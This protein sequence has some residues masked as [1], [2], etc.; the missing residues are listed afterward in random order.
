MIHVQL[1]HQRRLCCRGSSLRGPSLPGAAGAPQFGWILQAFW[2]FIVP[3]LEIDSMRKAGP[4]VFALLALLIGAAAA[5]FALTALAQQEAP[6]TSSSRW[7]DGKEVQWRASSAP[8]CD[9]SNVELRML[10][11]SSASGSARLKSATFACRRGG[12]DKGLERIFGLVAPG[13][14]AVA[15]ALT[16][17]CAEKGGVKEVLEVDVE[18]LRD[19]QGTEVVG[20]GC[21]FTG[22]Y[23]NGQRSGPGV[24]ACADG[25]RYDGA[26]SLGQQT[27]FAKETLVT[28]EIYEGQFI[29]GD[30]TG[31]GRMTY[32]DG[33]TYEGDFLKGLRHGVG[34]ARF[35]DG[36][37]YVGEWKD[38]KRVGHGTYISADKAWTFDGEWQNNFR[39]GPGKLTYANG[40]YTYEGAFRND[41]LDG[42]GTARFGDGREFRGLYVN[43]QQ[44][45]PGVLTFPDGRRITGDFRDHRPNGQAVET[46][47]S[48]TFDGQWLDGVLNGKVVATFSTG[49]RYEGMYANGK[50]HGMGIETQADGTREECNWINDVRQTP[51]NKITA[52]GKR[53]EY[54][55]QG[56]QRN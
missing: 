50:R 56:R 1:P 22:N 14:A 47:P 46:G 31:Q 17:A 53:I 8:G 16:C 37:E 25:Y 55:Q 4:R 39:N 19:G 42:Q 41:M 18:F 3:G 24:Y 27:G 10:N 49:Q 15:P 12:Q 2:E 34:T 32:R 52:D 30:R 33:S 5:P 51:C 26:W 36:S 28:G 13:S 23:L 48:A 54:R 29:D 11:N 6:W 43:N 40:S 20:N 45:G 35:K 7:P 38:D 9:G 21:T 44:A